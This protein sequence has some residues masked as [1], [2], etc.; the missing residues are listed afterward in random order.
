MPL[1]LP[2]LLMLVAQMLALLMVVDIL[3][4]YRN[5]EHAS[6]DGL[7]FLGLYYGFMTCLACLP[8]LAH[9]G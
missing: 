6:L 8:T 2:P 7:V 4:V 3:E 1:S 5:P 9:D